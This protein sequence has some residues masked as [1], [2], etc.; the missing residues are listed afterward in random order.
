[1]GSIIEVFP[2]GANLAPRGNA[3]RAW[4]AASA[5]AVEPP[6]ARLARLDDLAS[7]RALQHAVQP[8]APSA[9]PRQF[10][11]RRRGGAPGRGSA[12]GGPGRGGGPR[13]GRG[14]GAAPPA[15]GGGP[16]FPPRR[17]LRPSNA[18]AN[19]P[20]CAAPARPGLS[21]ASARD[22]GRRPTS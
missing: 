21:A 8:S 20:E 15:A 22:Y 1:M 2:R 19:A 16:L 6:R 7:I 17:N 13:G 4:R 9:T 12:V 3:R 14:R 18:R 10:E 5:L 11:A